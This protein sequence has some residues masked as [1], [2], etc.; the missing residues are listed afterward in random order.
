MKYENQ[1]FAKSAPYSRREYGK[2][3]APLH[4]AAKG[5][6]YVHKIIDRV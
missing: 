3:G 1:D 2:C 5:C 4:S 6:A